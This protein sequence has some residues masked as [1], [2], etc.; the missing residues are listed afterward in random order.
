MGRTK[1]RQRR[2]RKIVESADAEA[3]VKKTFRY[4][5][6]YLLQPLMPPFLIPENKYGKRY[7]NHKK[8]FP[9]LL[10]PRNPWNLFS[11]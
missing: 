3:V 6:V 1:K 10:E 2:N 7:K 8:I 9:G 11:N 5:N 4:T